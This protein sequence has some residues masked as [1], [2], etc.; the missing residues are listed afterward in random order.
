MRFLCVLFLIINTS[1]IANSGELSITWYGSTTLKLSDGKSSLLFDPFFT[2]PTLTDIVLFR[3]TTS[4]KKK[5]KKWFLNDLDNPLDGIIVSHTHYDH[6]LDLV[7][8]QEMTGAQV[9]GGNSTYNILKG[10]AREK[11]Y[12]K[13]SVGEVINIGAYKISVLPS[14]HSH[15]IA[16][17][18]FFDGLISSPLKLGSSIFNYKTGESFSF[19]IEHPFGNIYFNPSA[20]ITEDLK[21]SELPKI[22]ILIQGIIKRKSTEDLIENVVDELKPSIVIPVHFDDFFI[23][24]NEGLTLFDMA[25]TPEFIRTFKKKRAKIKLKLL[26]FSTPFKFNRTSKKK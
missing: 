14:K 26:D 24:L 23:P 4:D 8:L 16:G 1:A 5:I 17:I 19:L 11:S 25:E 18:T 7:V 6:V 12:I 9:Y 2:R 21:K 20:R 15:H 10:G 3:D 22:D 13:I